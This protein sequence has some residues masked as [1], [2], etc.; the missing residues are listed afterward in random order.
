MR[1]AACAA[2]ASRDTRL[3]NGGLTAS[4]FFQPREVGF[5]VSQGALEFIEELSRFLA[6]FAAIAKLGNDLMLP[7]HVSLTFAH[8]PL[9]HLQIGF[10][11]RRVPV[12][13]HP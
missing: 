8:V 5:V 9:D 11:A 2:A 13:E 6:Q 7:R 10:V 1:Q 12:Q 3:K 4:F